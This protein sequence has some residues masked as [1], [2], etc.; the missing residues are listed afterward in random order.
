M[1]SGGGSS[2]DDRGRGLGRRLGGRPAGGPAGALGGGDLQQTGSITGSGS[3]AFGR[4]E[5]SQR[6][7]EDSRG[8]SSSSGGR[9]RHHSGRWMG[10]RSAGRLRRPRSPAGGRPGQ[11]RRDAAGAGGGTSS[12]ASCG[13]PSCSG[14]SQGVGRWLGG[15][16]IGGP[17]GA[18]CGRVGQPARRS[19]SQRAGIA[20]GT[21]GGQGCVHSSRGAGRGGRD[22]GAG[23]GVG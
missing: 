15:R 8:T 2:R 20:R 21:S 9:N 16:P 18:V 13:G 1:R 12:S 3:E 14:R 17:L 6:S 23:R 4:T 7:R 10:G 11:R 19:S 22:P 5:R